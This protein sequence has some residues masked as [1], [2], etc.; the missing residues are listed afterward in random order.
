MLS[1]LD[2]AATP[3]CKLDNVSRMI[4]ELFLSETTPIYVEYLV[5]K[6]EITRPGICF[7]I[8]LMKYDQ[9]RVDFTRSGWVR[10]V[11]GLS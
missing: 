4:F 10:R 11:F 5:S 1:F 2:G 7:F 8:E 3:L 9:N 6:P